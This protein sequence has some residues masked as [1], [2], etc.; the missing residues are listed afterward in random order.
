MI[1]PAF[2]ASLMSLLMVQAAPTSGN[3]VKIVV[4]Y[5]FRDHAFTS[6]E[7]FSGSRYRQQS[8]AG[9]DN[10]E[11][12]HTARIVL[13]RD[14]TNQNFLLDLD[15]H[16][17]VA[18]ETDQR[19]IA[20]GAKSRPAERTR[21]MVDIWIES[22]DTGER[23]EMFGYTA[24]HIITRERRVPGQDSC[25]VPS[26]TEMDGWY[27]DYSFLPEWRQPQGKAFNVVGCAG[28]RIQ[29]HRSGPALGF[30]I[31]VVTTFQQI[32]ADSNVH[33]S[34]DTRE[35]VELCHAPLD[36]SLFEVPSDFRPVRK[37][38]SMNRPTFTAWD[39]FK[40]WLADIFR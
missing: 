25:S 19:G 6:T 2:A 35:V 20:V 24:R 33:A 40:G 39:R 29:L 22:T 3:D 13:R 12:H 4:R 21:G 5:S 1:F 27:I 18:F 17:Y 11:G 30:P 9:M 8:D 28:D 15:A 32:G 26:E 10:I 37:L 7:Y 14:I 23:Q 16:E 31:K 36:P 34:T 38:T